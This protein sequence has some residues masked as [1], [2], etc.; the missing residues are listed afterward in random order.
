M[1]DLIAKTPC[2]GLL[3]IEVGGVSLSE[4]EPQAIT[5]IM[6]FAGQWDAVSEALQ[7]TYGIAL[8][9]AGR[10]TGQG[11]K[12][13]IWTGAGQAMVLGPRLDAGLAGRAA[14]SDQSDAW[15]VMRLEGAGGEDVLARLTPLDLNPG[16]FKR[17]HVARSL[18]GHMNAVISR[19][20]A[21]AFEIM[22]FRSMAQTAVHEL[23]EAMKSVAARAALRP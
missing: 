4:V 12:R 6:P 5:S 3:P 23:E 8:P 14:L 15:A 17:G 11:E 20:G 7:S 10:M 16:V 22:V 2:A 13:A 18:L 9:A 19:V 1:V 21:E